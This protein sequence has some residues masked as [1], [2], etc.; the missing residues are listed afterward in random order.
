[1]DMDIDAELKAAREK[2]AD[3]KKASEEASKKRELERLRRELADD[4]AITALEEQQGVDNIRIIDT[5]KGCI[6]VGRPAEAEYKRMS[7]T[8]DKLNHSQAARYVQ[9]CVLY[10]A[11]AEYGKLVAEHPALVWPLMNAINSIAAAAAKVREGE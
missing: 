5:A 2:L 8:V 6:V 3:K 1:M 7:D 9:T 4:D 10:P 11:Q